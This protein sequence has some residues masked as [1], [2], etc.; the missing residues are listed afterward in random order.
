VSGYD[1]LGLLSYKTTDG[2]VDLFA[3]VESLQDSYGS[4]TNSG[5]TGGVFLLDGSRSKQRAPLRV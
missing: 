1:L 5:V 4:S 2:N 3:T